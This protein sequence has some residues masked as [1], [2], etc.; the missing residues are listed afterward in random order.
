MTFFPGAERH[1]ITHHHLLGVLGTEAARRGWGP[2]RAI[3]VLDMGCG[4]GS[5][6]SFLHEAAASLDPPLR[7]EIHGFDVA[8]AHVQREDFFAATRALLGGRHPQVDWPNRL[9]LV[10]SGDDWPYE[11]GSF[12]VVLS[13][14]VMEH[15]RDHDRALR[16]IA[17]VLAPGGFSAHLFPLGSSWIEWHLKI[18]F[19]HW[20]SNG[21]VLESYIRSASFL[22]I[23]TWR[24]YCRV[25]GP[26][27]LDEFARMN[28]DFL[29]FETNYLSERDV[30]RLSR[31]AGLRY[32]FRYTD[33]FYANRARKA[34]GLAM[35][36]RFAPRGAFWH[37]LRMVALKR[38]SSICLVLEGDNTYENR[39]FHFPGETLPEAAAR[40]PAAPAR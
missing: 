34:L 38:V 23:G 6:M 30:A 39:G 33:D 16:N 26:V 1:S 12:D 14:Q 19:A 25:V 17:R 21:D 4:S 8:D 31:S 35:T 9:R 37:R 18:P 20:I 40:D 29:A 7:L 11:P 32:S 27:P 3:R 2:D 22:G 10:A 24:K 36:Y 15:V 13:N 28:R 5:M